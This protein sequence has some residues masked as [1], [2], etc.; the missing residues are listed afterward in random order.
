MRIGSVDVE[1]EV[2]TSVNEKGTEWLTACARYPDS[3]HIT[4][5]GLTA[6]VSAAKASAASRKAR[7]R[8]SA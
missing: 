5:M 6:I 8:S 4:R 1:N 7:T 3:Y 2:A